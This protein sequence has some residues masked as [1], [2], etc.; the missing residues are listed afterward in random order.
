MIFFSMAYTAGW[1]LILFIHIVLCSPQSV[2]ERIQFDEHYFANGLV[3]LE[4]KGGCVSGK[5]RNVFVI[6][7]W[8]Q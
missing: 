6:F 5:I 1:W 7:F 3:Q 4:V 8:D 2:G